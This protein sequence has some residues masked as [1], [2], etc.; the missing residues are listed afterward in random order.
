MIFNPNNFTKKNFF[1]SSNNPNSRY[2]KV[3]NTFDNG[4]P[5]EQYPAQQRS[6]SPEKRNSRLLDINNGGTANSSSPIK[7]KMATTYNRP[8][9]LKKAM[10]PVTQNSKSFTENDEISA[11]TPSRNQIFRLDE[12]EGSGKDDQY[13]T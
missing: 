3:N 6:Q 2:N 8:F 11:G 1:P 12:Y 7:K 10:T 5:S 9:G 13:Y 4:A